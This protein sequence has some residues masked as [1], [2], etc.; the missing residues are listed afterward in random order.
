[1]FVFSKSTSEPHLV[2]LLTWLLVVA[3]VL[4]VAAIRWRLLSM[5]LERDEGEYAYAGQLIL[6]GI[7][8]YQEA[9]SVKFP[10]TSVAYALIML[11]FGKTVSGIHLGMIFVT[12]AS[13]MLVFLIGRRLVDSVT[14][15]VAA[16]TFSMLSANPSLF[17]LAGHATHF[18]VLF[19]L[20]GWLML[21]VPNRQRNPALL[22]SAGITFG[23]AI[24]MK[25]HA[26]FLAAFTAAWLCRPMPGTG[27]DPSWPARARHIG[28]F[29]TGCLL[30]LL[31]MCVWLWHAAVFERFVFWTFSYA[32]EYAFNQP[33]VKAPVRLGMA[34]ARVAEPSWGLWAMAAAGLVFLF[35]EKWLR[36]ARTFLVGL[37]TASFASICPGFVFRQHYF[38]LMLPV[39]ALLTG[40]AVSAG[41]RCVS[42]KE[43]RRTFVGVSPFIYLLAFAS[44]VFE[45]YAVWF[46]LTPVEASY[47]TFGRDQPFVAAIDVAE[48]IRVHS[49]PDNRVVVMGSEPEIYFLSQRH[50]AT[51][52]L[53]V[54][55]LMEPQPFALRMQEEFIHDIEATRPEYAVSVNLPKSWL[56]RPDSKRLVLEWWQDYSKSNYDIVGVIGIPDSGEP[57]YKWDQEARDNKCVYP[58][59]LT[60]FRWKQSAAAT[61]EGVGLSS[62]K[63]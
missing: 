61:L 35:W 29:L 52:Y 16:W 30:P 11:V 45:N 5:P 50:S 58:M 48:Y 47:A 13:T 9:Y 40:V 32:R 39:V 1:V 27:A 26:V 51:G 37:L 60:V 25:Q 19:S 38:I 49:A 36:P 46:S 28:V 3:A 12:S 56:P 14:G 63:E 34:F 31:V 22:L 42:A 7:S 6:Q 20:A 33:L 43:R 41:V 21:V 57:T 4:L 59:R 2:R 15:V 17:G 8:P 54:Y 18:V 44:G 23:V 62:S 10:G 24:L 55:P 53:Y